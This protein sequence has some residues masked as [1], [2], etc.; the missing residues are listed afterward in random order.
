[1][2]ADTTS[3]AAAVPAMKTAKTAAA[4]NGAELQQTR[5]QTGSIGAA[6]AAAVVDEHA[7]AQPSYSLGDCIVQVGGGTC[8]VCSWCVAFVTRC[9]TQAQFC[10]QCKQRMGQL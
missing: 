1:M 7:E 4:G 3:A 5:D 6:A 2:A 8:C 10:K 9:E